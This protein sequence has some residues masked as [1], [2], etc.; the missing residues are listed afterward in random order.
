MIS[1]TISQLFDFLRFG[2]RARSPLRELELSNSVQF[3]R[4][5]QAFMFVCGFI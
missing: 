5:E 4:C 3:L 1:L 2:H